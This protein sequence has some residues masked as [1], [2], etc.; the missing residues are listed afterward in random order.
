VNPNRELPETERWR[1]AKLAR[2]A[3]MTKLALASSKEEV[4]VTEVKTSTSY[5]LLVAA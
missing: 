1:K 3:H 5:Y 2:K 4:E